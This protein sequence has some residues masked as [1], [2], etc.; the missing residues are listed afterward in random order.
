M[1]IC[2]AR[3]VF[4]YFAGRRGAVCSL[5]GAV[6]NLRGA[7]CQMLSLILE[8]QTCPLGICFAHLVTDSL[9]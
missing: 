6:C 1:S 2:S 3:M 5:L 9:T 7:G 4:G 8:L